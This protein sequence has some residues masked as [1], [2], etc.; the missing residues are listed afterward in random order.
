MKFNF[1][2]VEDEVKILI[3][4]LGEL[5]HKISAGLHAKL[6][7]HAQVQAQQAATPETPADGSIPEQT[8]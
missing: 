3:H 1:E 4:A 8:K 5:P 6:C 2:F 7:Y